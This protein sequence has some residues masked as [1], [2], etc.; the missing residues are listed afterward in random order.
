MARTI[1]RSDVR[2]M[3]AATSV[4]YGSDEAKPDASAASDGTPWSGALGGH[5]EASV[6]R[7]GSHRSRRPASSSRTITSTACRYERTRAHGAIGT[8]VMQ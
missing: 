6:V 1:A 8:K 5:E 3:V 4:G 7:V 2:A